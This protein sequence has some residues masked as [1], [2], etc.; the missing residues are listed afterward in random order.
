MSEVDQMLEKLPKYKGRER[1]LKGRQYTSDIMKAILELH[2]RMGAHYDSIS[3]D[4]WR[5]DA[6]TTA[7]YL[8]DFARRNLPYQEEHTMMQT[9]KTPAAILKERY[10]F[11]NDCKHYASFIVGMADA[12]RRKGYPVEAFYRFASYKKGV[13]SP[14]HVFAVFKHNG[15]E[16]WADPV[17][18]IPGFDSRKVTPV[19]STDK[20][21]PVMESKKIGSLYEISGLPV[22]GSQIL[23]GMHDMAVGRCHSRGGDWL[24]AYHRHPMAP[25]PNGRIIQLQPGAPM[26]KGKKKFKLKIPKIKVPKI[27]VGQFLKKAVG[28]P[29]RNAFLL[30]VKLNVFHLATRMWQKAARDKNSNAWHTLANKWHSLGG[31]PDKLYKEI[32]RGVKTFNKLHKSKKAVALNGLEEL[33]N[34]YE[35]PQLISGV[36]DDDTKVPVSVDYIGAPYHDE[37]SI[38]AIFDLVGDNHANRVQT[39]G[40]VQAAGAA[41]IIAAAAPILAAMKNILKSFGIDTKKADDTADAATHKM[42]KKHNDAVDA[43]EG[44]ESGVTHEDGTKTTVTDNADGTQSF[45]TKPAGMSDKHQA[46]ADGD[47][48]DDASSPPAKKDKGGASDGTGI[49]DTVKDYISEHK[50]PLIATGAGAAMLAYSLGK[51]AKKMGA[52]RPILGV[53]GGA[54]MVWGGLNL[55]NKQ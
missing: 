2:P 3:A 12:L 45:A 50:M 31:K 37:M 53:A 46:D 17:P 6:P 25:S 4:A 10:H 22:P 7:Q 30:L 21:P 41:A 35:A 8:Y 23:T 44:D 36:D 38:G 54:A 20:R 48:G 52:M 55:F 1:L 47:G 42:A 26:G 11:G 19:Y 9:V 15:R 51:S 16:I 27:K 24:Y 43:G 33:M 34:G 18:Q 32:V 39:I 5:G 14:G 29:S 28:A 49:L 40:V 13:K